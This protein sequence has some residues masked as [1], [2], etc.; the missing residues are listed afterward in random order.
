[1][2]LCV[3]TSSTQGFN[4]CRHAATTG[5]DHFDVAPLALTTIVEGESGE[6]MIEYRETTC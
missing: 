3:P 6:V 4:A 1:M 2:T 5:T